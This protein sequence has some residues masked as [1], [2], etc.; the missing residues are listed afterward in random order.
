MLKDNSVV[1]PSAGGYFL[2]FK[3]IAVKQFEVNSGNYYFEEVKL[4]S[5]DLTFSFNSSGDFSMTKLAHLPIPCLITSFF[6]S[7]AWFFGAN[8][9][10]SMISFA[11][12]RQTWTWA[13][14][15]CLSV[16][17]VSFPVVAYTQMV[18]F[19]MLYRRANNISELS[20]I[21]AAF[22]P[23]YRQFLIGP[24][25]S[26]P[27][28]NDIISMWQW[29]FNYCSKSRLG[30]LKHLVLSSVFEA[31]NPV[32]SQEQRRFPVDG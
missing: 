18:I 8:Y 28:C 3:K 17:V 32:S 9:V 30:T 4:V 20:R 14:L 5:P 2:S 12:A 19:H 10:C 1:L 6:M 24:R 15:P 25:D 11:V 21:I 7:L 31:K 29:S 23:S 27:A 16:F 13:C 26:R 22:G